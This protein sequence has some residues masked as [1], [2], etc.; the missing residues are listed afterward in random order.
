MGYADPIGHVRNWNN[1]AEV[2][3]PNANLSGNW[4]G[5]VTPYVYWQ[6]K[7]I[8]NYIKVECITDSGGAWPS[9]QTRSLA[10]WKANYNTQKIIDVYFDFA[11][12]Y[13][14]H[15]NIISYNSNWTSS[16]GTIFGISPILTYK[17]NNGDIIDYAAFAYGLRMAERFRVIG[18]QTYGNYYNTGS[19]FIMTAYEMFEGWQLKTYTTVSTEHGW[20]I[21]AEIPYSDANYNK[22]LAMAACFGCPFTDTT[23]TQY[24]IDFNDNDIFVPVIDQQGVAHGEFTRGSANIGNPFLSKDSVYD[25]DYNPVGYD[26]LIGDKIVRK[27]YLGGHPLK[28]AYFADKKL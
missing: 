10:D 28:G 14:Y 1:T 9:T 11:G 4:N 21:W 16:T 5:I 19:T 20:L 15:D 8:I 6:T 27:I 23:K 24:P 26:I 13:S 7:S 18:Y 3:S 17:T 25:Y 2:W 22:I 12:Y